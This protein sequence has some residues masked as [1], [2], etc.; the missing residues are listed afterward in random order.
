MKIYTLI[1]ITQTKKHRNNSSDKIAVNQQANYMTFIQTLTLRTNILI[2]NVVIEE[3]TESALKELGFGSDY[4]GKNRVWTVTCSKD[5]GQIFP[6][7]TTLLSDF[8]LVP[9]LSD[10]NETILINNNVFK[11]QGKTKNITIEI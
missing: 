11:T 10:L 7:T 2:D 6:D 1:D 9:V 5:E 4:K 8:N 3:K